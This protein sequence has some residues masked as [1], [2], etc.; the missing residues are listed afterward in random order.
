MSNA[1][2]HRVKYSTLPK[3]MWGK[4]AY[5]VAIH[6]PGGTW[7][8]RD[9]IDY[10]IGRMS[11]KSLDIIMAACPKSEDRFKLTK[12]K[13]SS[14]KFYFTNKTDFD[15]FCD[16]ATVTC[17]YHVSEII[18]PSTSDQLDVLQENGLVV[19]RSHWFHNSYE[20]KVTF[21]PKLGPKVY[22]EIQKWIHDNLTDENDVGRFKIRSSYDSLICYLKHEDDVA[23]TK[24]TY[25]G[26]IFN[27]AKAVVVEPIVYTNNNN[28]KGT[29]N[30]S[31]PLSPT[32][33]NETHH[34]GNDS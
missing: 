1:S 27:V 25:S 34:A 22:G 11:K 21:Q 2:K 18:Q 9:N 19:Y 10:R 23:M 26:N 12:G 31:S 3:L 4:F 14:W 5:V 33:R 30:A 20:W 13:R 7:V 15:R 24:L 32:S 28:N 8:Y 17:R 16:I 29:T 6:N